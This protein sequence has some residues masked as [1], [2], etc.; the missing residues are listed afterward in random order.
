MN[1]FDNYFE[2]WLKQ[3]IR[4]RTETAA[5]PKQATP[6][7]EPTVELL[8]SQMRADK[9]T[10]PAG[11]RL[12]AN[13]LLA[14]LFSHNSGCRSGDLQHVVTTTPPVHEIHGE[15]RYLVFITDGLK[16][17]EGST[18]LIIKPNP[19]ASIC[20]QRHWEVYKRHLPSPHLFAAQSKNKE[21]VKT[22]TSNLVAAWRKYAKEA[23]VENP[24]EISDHS[25]R[26]AFTQQAFN[27]GAALQEINSQMH[28][29]ETSKMAY[30]Y[31]K[32][33]T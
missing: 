17:I 23:G 29:K 20:A 13:R 3:L 21:D 1:T 28:G 5:Q 12:R 14:L 8:A 19:K 24:N 11:H 4:Q 2:H 32:R 6:I 15:D 25:W 27:S 18:K 30:H 31:A 26:R 7:F 22:S 33:D 10:S 9:P 16:T